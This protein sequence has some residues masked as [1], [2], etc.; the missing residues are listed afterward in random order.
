[1]VD[2]IYII[3]SKKDRDTFIASRKLILRNLKSLSY[4]IIVPD[5]EY[6][7]FSNISSGFNLIKESEIIGGLA[8]KFDFKNISLKKWYLQQILKIELILK[9]P[10]GANVLVWDGDTIPFK[11]IRLLSRGLYYYYKSNEYHDIYFQTISKLLGISRSVNFSFISQHFICRPEWARLMINSIEK[12]TNKHYVDSIFEIAK[13]SSQ[14]TFSEYETLG[15]FVNRYF[16]Y[17]IDFL[18][19]NKWF[20][21]GNTVFH[22]PHN[23]ACFSSGF[24]FI[25]FESWESNFSMS[26]RLIIK[27]IFF[28][29][30]FKRIFYL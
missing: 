12:N 13:G 22:S 6:Y 24:D 28:T 27:F 14:H 16:F 25:S 19:A 26:K 29:R 1:M 5:D 3:L 2:Y 20:R 30:K 8:S 21:F 18:N 10:D 7:L 23:K 17:E 4:T 15:T 11:K 9:S